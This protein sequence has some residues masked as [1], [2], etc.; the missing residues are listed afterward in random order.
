MNVLVLNCGSS[1][2]KY[3]LMD[4]KNSRRLARGLIER[5]GLD[6][7]VVNHHY[8]EGED[9]KDAKLVREVKTHTQG[10][11]ILFELLTDE[12]LGVIK[13]F[14]DI[15]GV[16]HRV[17]HGGEHYT[18]PV[19]VTEDVKND[20]KECIE[21][22]PLHN[23]H[24]LA[25]IEAIEDLIPD[26]PQ[27][28]VF[29]TAFH[30]SME[31]SSYMYA[32]PYELYTKYGI[33]RYGFHGTSHRYV[34][35]RAAEMVG[36]PIEELKI[37][38]CHL[39]NGASICAIDGG[40][41]VNTSMGFTPLAGLVMGTRSGDF[42]PMILLYL[43]GKE[44]LSQCEA[45][46]LINKYSGLAGISGVSGDFREI[47]ESCKEGHER[48]Q[49][50]VDMTALRIKH[51]IGSYA[52]QMNGL[53]LLIFTA[54]IGENSVELREYTCQDMD[55]LGISIDKEKNK[56]AR[57]VEGII[58]PDSSKVKVMVVPTDEELLIAR[59]TARIISER[60]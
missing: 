13:D 6:D 55:Y 15:Y 4:M 28:A 10:I 45:N 25:G 21:L 41:S 14:K 51:F 16:G 48:A 9:Y 44:S 1:S 29:D 35:A 3:E 59:E 17:V 31:P 34:S 37:I 23:P 26:Q 52:A 46:T 24:H 47:I 20:I 57:G 19:Y 38:C 8:L 60:K 2:V 27:V 22:A 11:K 40:K 39:G 12:K 58:S 53:D 36:K 18:G 30:Q 33:R 42:D 56:K 43:M 54:G 32:F 49:L 5:I 50:A 7:A